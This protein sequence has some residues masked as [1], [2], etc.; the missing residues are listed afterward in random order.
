[1]IFATKFLRA[2]ETHATPADANNASEAPKTSSGINGQ[3]KFRWRRKDA[4][5]R[6]ST[7]T[8]KTT[9][10]S[11][12][13]GATSPIS[14]LAS[15]IQKP[16]DYFSSNLIATERSALLASTSGSNSGDAANDVSSLM[17]FLQ[18]EVPFYTSSSADYYY[19]TAMSPEIENDTFLFHHDQG[20]ALF[21]NPLLRLQ[22]PLSD[23]LKNGAFFNKRIN[24][25]P[26][27]PHP[28]PISSPSFG[29]FDWNIDFG[30][31][32]N[33]YSEVRN[34]PACVAPVEPKVTGILARSATSP[35]SV[36]VF[37][38][39]DRRQTFVETR[40]VSDPTN[41]LKQSKAMSIARKTFG[42]LKETFRSSSFVAGS[43][44]VGNDSAHT[45]WDEL[46]LENM[47]QCCL[48]KSEYSRNE[49][50]SLFLDA[51]KNIPVSSALSTLALKFADKD[52]GTTSECFSK[53]LS[54]LKSFVNGSSGPTQ[55][56]IDALSRKK[57]K[58][59]FPITNSQQLDIT[60][61]ILATMCKETV[62]ELKVDPEVVNSEEMLEMLLQC[63]DF[64]RKQ[65]ARVAKAQLVDYVY[66]MLELRQEIFSVF[67]NLCYVGN[68]YARFLEFLSIST[69]SKETLLA[70]ETMLTVLIT[71]LTNAKSSL[72]KVQ[73]AIIQMK[74]EVDVHIIPMVSFA[75]ETIRIRS[76][77][78]ETYGEFCQTAMAKSLGMPTVNGSTK[79]VK[80]LNESDFLVSRK[81]SIKTELFQDALDDLKHWQDVV[82]DV[83]I[84]L[85]I[86]IWRILIGI[87]A[88]QSPVHQPRP[89]SFVGPLD[90]DQ[91]SVES[92]DSPSSSLSDEGSSYSVRSADSLDMEMIRELENGSS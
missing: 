80:L 3:R 75:H 27:A 44:N 51:M 72:D 53:T 89:T 33:V 24:G 2:A 76:E 50:F 16:S 21:L 54:D 60:M 74:E 23:D 31:V 66:D 36:R 56:P 1:M 13:L 19:H 45:L 65:Y 6:T 84:D 8:Q 91:R 41:K 68:M 35:Q 92:C 32:N 69:S 46:A 34:S 29:S 40:N 9:N 12:K 57:T 15:Y 87:S 81:E 10:I 20:N 14:R 83:Q 18:T 43:W 52:H 61:K 58:Q 55:A 73:L 79:F 39:C 85:E 28:S 67:K 63:F 78:S 77:C 11:V 88:M 48:F 49:G 71:Q 5:F 62:G 86:N 22:L 37:Y 38:C 82:G 42:L 70:A 7:T 30:E 64:Y 47:A 25:E 59:S 90:S 4:P 26:K 17:E